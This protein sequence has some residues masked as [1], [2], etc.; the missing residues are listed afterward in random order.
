MARCEPQNIRPAVRSSL[1]WVRLA[2]V[3]KRADMSDWLV[4]GSLLTST[5]SRP[6]CSPGL[7]ARRSAPSGPARTRSRGPDRTAPSRPVTTRTAS[8]TSMNSA[9][10]RCDPLRQA[11]GARRARLAVRRAARADLR[12]WRR[13][14]S[15][16]RRAQPRA[17]GRG[18]AGAR[19]REQLVDGQPWLLQR[20]RRP[21][22]PLHRGA[23]PSRRQPLY[24]HALARSWPGSS[25]LLIPARHRQLL[26][27]EVTHCSS[28]RTADQT[29][30]AAARL[31]G[32]PRGG[33]PGHNLALIAAV[34]ERP[35]AGAPPVG[36]VSGCQPRECWTIKR[37][38]PLGPLRD[39]KPLLL[40]CL[41]PHTRY[42]TPHTTHMRPPFLPGR[43]LTTHDACPISSSVTP[44]L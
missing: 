33:S 7:R 23:T 15:A 40:A 8:C 12:A 36:E 32:I 28:S 18:V 14:W 6:R 22:L 42:L 38:L 35:P 39:A 5:R 29:A 34:I 44:R 4:G 43:W 17:R 1:L 25:S 2:H 3:R 21:H 19:A 24:Q 31:C 30:Q 10:A 27:S 16:A 20:R 26:A 41:S 37:L 11:G 13:R 9:P